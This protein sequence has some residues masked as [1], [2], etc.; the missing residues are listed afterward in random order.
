MER[1]GVV[2][3]EPVMMKRGDDDEDDGVVVA[4]PVMMKRGDDGEEMRR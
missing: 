2:V 4:E 3:A 1:G